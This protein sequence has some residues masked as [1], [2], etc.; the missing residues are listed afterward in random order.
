MNE[1]FVV[2]S[3]T[4]TYDEE[5]FELIRLHDSNSSLPDQ[6]KDTFFKTSLDISSI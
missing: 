1:K 3:L 2:S 5:L 4:M 6:S